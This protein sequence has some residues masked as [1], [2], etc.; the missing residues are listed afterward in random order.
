MLATVDL[1]Y[2]LPAHC[3]ARCPAEPRDSAR[4]M[5]IPLNGTEPSHR[6][7]RE[8]P[9]LLRAGDLL[10][11]NTS[12]VVPARVLGVRQ[13]TGGKI[14]GLCLG[15]EAGVRGGPTREYTGGGVGA[16]FVMML[17]GKRLRPGIRLEL[18]R[19]DETSG[20][21][22]RLLEPWPEEAG[23][24][25]IEVE[26]VDG[27]GLL[28][29]VGRT[30]LPPYILAARRHEQENFPERVDRARYQTV[31]AGPEGSVAAPTAGLHLTPWL[32]G[33][34][35]A[36]GIETAEVVLHVGTGTFRPVETEFVEQHPIHAEWCMLPAV[37]AQQIERA[38]RGGRRVI[39]VGT[40]ACRVL[41]TF[42]AMEARG[43]LEK[44]RWVST[45]ILITPGHAW[46]WT[47]GLL[48]NFHLP[49]S[50]LMALVAA[51]MP[52][53]AARLREM[54]ELAVREGYRF[55]SFGDA[56]LIS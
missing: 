29:A 26:Q 24:W 23:A 50:S 18:R 43:E 6:T 1:E 12:R 35:A 51:L 41:E 19:E 3:I 42:G 45:R 48:T 33:E 17:R 7:V 22:I 32:L 14:E 4:L 28:E 46:T 20:A 39:A 10:V 16:R 52:G 9:E 8:L 49:R 54:Y 11:L 31:Y 15:D 5:H 38:R 55:Y 53:G 34:L 37:S 40:T 36:K 30:P 27:A 13:D 25:L 21:V 56:T 2:E 47:N 44:D